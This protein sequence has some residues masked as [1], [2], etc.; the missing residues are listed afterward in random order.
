MH[1]NVTESSVGIPKEKS[2]SNTFL[3][4][5]ITTI[6]H[7][8]AGLQSAFVAHHPHK[9]LILRSRKF[10]QHCICILDKQQKLNSFVNMSKDNFE[11]IQQK[12]KL[13]PFILQNVSP[14]AS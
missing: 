12:Y 5:R 10:L 6:Y 1:L 8:S 14:L 11:N 7:K 3:F 2:T 13:F 4:Q 9:P